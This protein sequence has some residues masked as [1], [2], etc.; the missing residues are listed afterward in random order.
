MTG[1]E[2]EWKTVGGRAPDALDGAPW[3][4]DEPFPGMSELSAVVR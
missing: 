4:I 2:G 3:L 1:P